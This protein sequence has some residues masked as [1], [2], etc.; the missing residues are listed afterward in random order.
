MARRHLARERAIL[1]GVAFVAALVAIGTA[2]L[3]GP[4][5]VVE[6]I[7]T[8]ERYITQPVDDGTTVGLTYTHSVEKSR[9]YDEYRVQDSRLVNTRMEF[10]SYGWGLPA[11]A[12]VTTVDGTFVYDPASPIA[13]FD[14]LSVSPGRVAGHTLTIGGR[15]YDLVETTNASDVRIYVER[16]PLPDLFT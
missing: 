6:D 9:V 8:T 4:V 13:E 11:G 1:F 14:S 10:E 16:R 7:D 12:N 5:L 2:L 15:Q 3:S